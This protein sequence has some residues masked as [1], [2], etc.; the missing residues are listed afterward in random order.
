MLTGVKL[1]QRMALS[2]LE[3]FNVF[4]FHSATS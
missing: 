4:D 2:V 1:N 3:G